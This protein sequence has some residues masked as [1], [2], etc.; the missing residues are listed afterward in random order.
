MEKD[1]FQRKKTEATGRKN[2]GPTPKYA[3]RRVLVSGYFPASVAAA[4]RQYAAGIQIPM[5]AIILTAVREHL[6][7]P[8]EESQR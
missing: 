4:L 7:L 8:F 1:N 6:Q 2:P 3:G 5:S